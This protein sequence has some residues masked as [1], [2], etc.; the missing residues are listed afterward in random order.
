MIHENGRVFFLY[1]IG[2]NLF[3]AKFFV[4]LFAA[5]PFWLLYAF[6]DFTYLL[7]YRVFRYRLTVVRE[8]LVYSFPNKDRKELRKIERRFYHHFCDLIFESLK[9]PGISEDEMKKRMQFINYKP[10]LKHYDEGRSVMLHTSHYCNWEWTSSFAIYLPGDKPLYGVYKKQK[11]DTTN[12]VIT[13]IRGHFGSQALEMKSLLRKMVAMRQNGE[14]GMFGML[15]DQSPGRSSMNYFTQFLNQHTAVITGT[16][17][18]ARKFD[19]PVYYARL[20]KVKRGYYTC[21]LIPVSLEPKLSQEHE[22]SEK[23]MRLLEEDI[24]HDPA[25]WLWTHKRWKH[26]RSN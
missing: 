14:L 17:Q 15:S 16:E 11:S 6:S 10:L 25:Y 18:L 1:I 20:R 7:I 19:F 12:K 9:L 13:G 21:E 22:I 2:M 24:L 4:R 26:T 8:N 23:Y 3:L 5:L